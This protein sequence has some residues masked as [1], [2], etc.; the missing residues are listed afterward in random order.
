[1]SPSDTSPNVSL[2]SLSS[3]KMAA[4]CSRCTLEKEPRRIREQTQPQ[5]ACTDTQTG[6]CKRQRND[7]VKRRISKNIWC[8]KSVKTEKL[9]VLLLYYCI[10]MIQSPTWWYSKSFLSLKKKKCIY[11]FVFCTHFRLHWGSQR[12]VGVYPSCHRV[13]AG[14]HPEQASKQPLTLIQTHLR[15]I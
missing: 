10:L 7:I 6:N 14:L 4:S 13:K 15:T 1:M 9:E 11:P 12:F 5:N 3:W 2:L 8:Q